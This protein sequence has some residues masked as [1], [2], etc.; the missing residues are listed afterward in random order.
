MTWQSH[1]DEASDE[2][3]LLSFGDWPL[4]YRYCSESISAALKRIALLHAVA[5][6]V[7]FKA[8]LVNEVLIIVSYHGGISNAV[9]SR[10]V[11]F[12]TFK[13]S[14]L[15]PSASSTLRMYSIS[16]QTTQFSCCRGNGLVKH[17]ET[18]DLLTTSLTGNFSSEYN[19]FTLYI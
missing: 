9:T 11:A 4:I 6:T 12:I 7:A 5:A 14:C 8:A 15:L 10:S 19:Y 18:E 3:F 2:V 1:E 16:E 17:P 13:N